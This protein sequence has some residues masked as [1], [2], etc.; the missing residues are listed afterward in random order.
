[1]TTETTEQLEQQTAEQT[2]QV[3]RDFSRG[4]LGE[5]ADRREA[6]Y[7]ETCVIFEAEL[8][9]LAAE[10]ADLEAEMP[11]TVERLASAERVTRFRADELILAGKAEQAREK[12]RELEVSKGELARL[13][14]RRGEIAERCEQLEAEKKTALRRSAEDFKESSIALIRGAETGLALILDGARN[15]LNN[16]EAQIGETLYQPAQLTADEKSNEWRT[17]NRLYGGRGR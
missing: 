8:A 14:A 16:L 10:L 7:A 5:L 6:S 17:L 12:L 4:A 1:M 9:E 15:T 2:A 13:E 11:S 3:I